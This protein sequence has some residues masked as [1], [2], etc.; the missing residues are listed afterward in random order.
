MLRKSLFALGCAVSMA[1]AGQAQAAIIFTM[2]PESAS[3]RFDA[4]IVSGVAGNFTLTDTFARPTGFN[5]VTATISSILIPSNTPFTD[6]NLFDVYLND[7]LFTPMSTGDWES[8]TLFP[9]IALRDTNT[10]TIN[11][12]SGGGGTITGSFAFSAGAI[13][14][15][16]TWGLMILGFGAVGVALRRRQKVSAK[17]NFA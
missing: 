16:A 8:Q 2:T 1:F 4:D 5:M 9:E 11:G 13:P 14:E 3:G 12:W 15:P 10:L 7:V 17:L 6:I